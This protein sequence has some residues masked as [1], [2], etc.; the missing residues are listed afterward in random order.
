MTK[1]F[2][3]FGQAYS[4]VQQGGLNQNLMLTKQRLHFV[5]IIALL[6]LSS[7]ANNSPALLNKPERNSQFFPKISLLKETIIESKD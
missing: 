2:R 4:R 5:S 1:G 6:Q 3:Y 7:C